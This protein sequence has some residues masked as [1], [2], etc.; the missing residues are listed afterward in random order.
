[1]YTY[2]YTYNHIYIY[3]FSI[4]IYDIEPTNITRGA[5]SMPPCAVLPGGAASGHK[6]TVP[7]DPRILAGWWF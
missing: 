5:S 2:I 6:P 7:M 3:R 4:I 1:M